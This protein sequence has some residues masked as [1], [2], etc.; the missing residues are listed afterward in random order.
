MPDDGENEARFL[1]KNFVIPAQERLEKKM[2]TIA[3]CQIDLKLQDEIIKAKVSALELAQLRICEDLEQHRNDIQSHY[4]PYHSE[5][6]G[7]KL[8]RKKLE[9]AAGGS[10]G[11]FVAALLYFIMER[12]GG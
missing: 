8:W 6:A 1:I 3:A 11:T 10:L 7:Q 2:E 5:T 4:N 9:I 12:L